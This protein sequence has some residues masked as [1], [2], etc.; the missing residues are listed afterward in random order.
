MKQQI[1]LICTFALLILSACSQEPQRGSVTVGITQIASHPALDE[2][3]EGI[4][5]GLGRHGF[6]AGEN[7]T[8]IER[9]ANGDTTL[10]F[11]IAQDFV[12]KKV[13]LIIPITT[14][15]SLAAARS[16]DT[17]PIL[18]SGVSY[19]IRVGIVE[20]MERP[21]KNITGMS[22]QWPFALQMQSYLKLFPEK[23]R[24]GMLYKKGDD[25]A[26][27]GFQKITAL[28]KEFNFE[29]KAA[30]IHDANDLALV[31][32]KLIPDV[33]VLYTGIDNLVLE[34][35]DV[36]L[37]LTGEYG[38][39]VIAGESGA[40]KKG[41]L[42]AVSIDMHEFGLRT[43]DMAARIL[44]GESPGTIPVGVMNNGK[45]YVNADTAKR[46]GVLDQISKDAIVMR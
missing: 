21:G 31:A 36:I 41:A 24:V 17:I 23:R 45:L 43:A 34:N 40:V 28:S 46:F 33:D 19:P 42:L 8:L 12:R 29:L 1:A 37:K 7:L 38:K 44:N 10:A 26:E 4:K 3:R 14:P 35:I 2:V 22:D 32:R 13:D 16:S 20:S 39:P 15:S 30:V 27:F 25:V 11:S 5:E 6:R 18:F 9:N